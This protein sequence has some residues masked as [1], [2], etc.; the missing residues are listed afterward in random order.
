MSS[1]R[2]G[3]QGYSMYPD[4]ILY[5]NITVETVYGAKEFKI[6]LF[7][8]DTETLNRKGMEISLLSISS[9]EV[10]FAKP[11]I[12]PVPY[13]SRPNLQDCVLE[14]YF[15]LENKKLSWVMCD[16]NVLDKR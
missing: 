9:F 1:Y 14:V 4:V 13:W 12:L 11:T 7:Q 15:F 16:F 6:R 2:I 5:S 10:L 3:V 8:I